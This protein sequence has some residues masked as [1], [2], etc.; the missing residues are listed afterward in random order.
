MNLLAI[1]PNEIKFISSKPKYKITQYG[2]TLYM[3]LVDISE[4]MIADNIS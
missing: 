2:L 1:K 4:V 3:T